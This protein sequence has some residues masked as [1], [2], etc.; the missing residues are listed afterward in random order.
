MKIAYITAQAPYSSGEAFILPE[1]LEL[2]RKG[3]E[4]TVFPLRPNRKVGPGIECQEVANFTKRIPLIDLSVFSQTIK[5]AIKHPTIFIR[6][7]SDIVK[8]SGSLK[9]IIKNIAVIPK[10]LV[11]GEEIKKGNFDHIHAHWASTP[12]TAAYIASLYSGVSWSFTAHRWDIVESNMLEKKVREASF[13]RTISMNGANNVKSKIDP[14]LWQKIVTIHMGVKLPEV[15]CTHVIKNEFLIATIGNLL[16]VKGHKF[17][18][19]ACSQLRNQGRKFE[20]LVIGD[21]PEEMELKRLS[22]ELQLN[23]VIQFLGRIPHDEV[24]RLL[25]SGSI[26]AVVHPSI[27]TKD[28][29]E[30]GIPVAL[31]EAMA[32]GI[33]VISTTTGGIPELLGNGAGLLVP[34]QDSVSLA[35]AIQSLMDDSDLWHKLSVRGRKKVEKDFSI[36][37]VAEELIKLFQAHSHTP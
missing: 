2:M 33:P 6:V 19:Q 8:Y 21:G 1:V 37:S 11:I 20:C 16:P 28:G 26:S 5:L 3:C 10:G 18:I 34:P 23:D 12:S 24:L 9:K 25:A 36:E 4:V 13:A 14:E 27:L 31:M 29:E 32:S 7:I 35:N 17:L 30:E 22:N 15:H